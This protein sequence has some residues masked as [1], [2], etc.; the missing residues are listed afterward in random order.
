MIFDSSHALFLAEVFGVLVMPGPTNS[1]LFVSG[2]ARGLR[3]GLHLPVAELTAY[4]MTISV[5]VFLVGP[6]ALGHSILSQLLR[7]VCGIYLVQMAVFLWRSGQPAADARHPITFR[8]IF[9]TTLVNP[10]NLLFAFVIF[11]PPGLGADAMLLSFVSFSGI[12][13]FAGLGWIAAGGLLRSTTASTIHL[14]HFY[15]GEAFVLAGFAIMILLSA[16]YSL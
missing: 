16:Y 5:L 8:R 6:A 11:P 10:K 3:A 7:V 15:R 4:L 13:L 2:T 9:V 12:C 14:H 1:L